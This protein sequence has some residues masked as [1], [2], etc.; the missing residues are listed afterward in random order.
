MNICL[1]NK[2]RAAM[3][4]MIDNLIHGNTIN[5]ELPHHKEMARFIINIKTKIHSKLK[6]IPITLNTPTVCKKLHLFRSM[7]SIIKIA[8]LNLIKIIH[9]KW[10]ILS[11]SRHF[12]LDHNLNL[13]IEFMELSYL[14]SKINKTM[15]LKMNN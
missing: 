6:R 2:I 4:I 5:I 3:R 10:T 9:T 1:F 14:L 11:K 12:N 15:E 13:W 7:D 8:P